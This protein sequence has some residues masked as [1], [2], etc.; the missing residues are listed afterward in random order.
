MCFCCRTTCFFTSHPLLLAI[1][2]DLLPAQLLSNIVYNFS[3]HCDSRYVCRTSQRL[4][5]RIR[6]HVPQ[7]IRIGRIPQARNIFTRSDK[8]STPI[9]FSKSTIREHLL[10]NPMCAKNYIDKKFTIFLF[11]CLSFHVSA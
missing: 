8:P 6:Q 3:F 4:Q 2:K 5:D 10:D 7:F 1:K 9:I 11:G